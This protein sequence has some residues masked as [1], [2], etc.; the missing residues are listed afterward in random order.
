MTVRLALFLGCVLLCGC[1]THQPASP[2]RSNVPAA[3]P[4]EAAPSAVSQELKQAQALMVASQ[5]EQA[6]AL[7]SDLVG[8]EKFLQRSLSEQ[9]VAAAC[10]M[11]DADSRDWLIR[12]QATLTFLRAHTDD[13]PSAS[14][15]ALLITER[16]AEGAALL[17]SRLADPKRRRHS[18]SCVSTRKTRW[19]RTSRP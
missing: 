15:E 14:Q 2:A 11:N 6:D 18:P 7:L 19:A 4:R 9:H 17:I 12:M 16:P 13:A 3:A 1:A 5:W 10:A 8:A